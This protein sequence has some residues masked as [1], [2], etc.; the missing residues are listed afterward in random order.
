[1]FDRVFTTVLANRLA[2]TIPARVPSAVINA[3]L[4][5]SSVSSFITALTTGTQ[6]AFQAVQGLTPAI[7]AI[8]VRAYKEANSDAFH[9]VFLT[10]LAFSGTGI[11]LS[12]LYP[13]VD[14]LLTK[15]VSVQVHKRGMENVSGVH[16]EEKRIESQ[17]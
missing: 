14:H 7:Q 5:S 8:G 13:S 16:D 2:Q 1:V 4:P 11:L 12:T 3:G 6:S 9:T 10:S 15:E 17:V